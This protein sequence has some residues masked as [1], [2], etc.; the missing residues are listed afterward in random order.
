MAGTFQDS[1][2]IPAVEA[3]QT[4]ACSHFGG[5]KPFCIW[6]GFS[7]ATVK[8]AMRCD[9][10]HDLG[11]IALHSRATAWTPQIYSQCPSVSLKKFDFIESPFPSLPLP[12]HKEL[13]HAVTS[14]RMH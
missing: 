1:P 6:N 10:S 4:R 7:A 5:A 3:L 2:R 8:C 11:D 9:H 14:Q 13:S 12:C